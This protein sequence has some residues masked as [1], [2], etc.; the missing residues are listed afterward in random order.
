MEKQN[1]DLRE[2][3]DDELIKKGL[4]HNL[5]IQEANEKYLPIDD[6]YNDETVQSNLPAWRESFLEFNG[7]VM[8]HIMNN[9]TLAGRIGDLIATKTSSFDWKAKELGLNPSKLRESI[10]DKVR[11]GASLTR[12]EEEIVDHF[13][14]LDEK[15]HFPRRMSRQQIYKA[16]K[17]AYIDAQKID[18]RQNPTIRDVNN[19]IGQNSYASAMY[20]GTGADLTIHFWYNF[21][22]AI[23]ETAYPWF[24]KKDI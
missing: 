23:I 13:V 5:L 2:L 15:N 12:V 8:D 11:A 4:F 6:W 3:S 22:D 18:A 7:E 1:I 20:S 9:H 10:L 24:S 17:E 21:T 16:I 14:K 19:A